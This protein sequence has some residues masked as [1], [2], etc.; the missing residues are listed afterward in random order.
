MPGPTVRVGQ[1][2]SRDLSH[3]PLNLVPSVIRFFLL[4]LSALR[5]GPAVVAIVVPRI[6]VAQ[7]RVVETTT[8]GRSVHSAAHENRRGRTCPDTDAECQSR[9]D[10][11]DADTCRDDRTGCVVVGWM[12]IGFMAVRVIAA[13]TATPLPR[14]GRVMRRGTS[15]PARIIFWRPWLVCFTRTDSPTT[16]VQ[17]M[18]VN[19][20]AVEGWS[21]SVVIR[22]ESSGRP[23]NE[24]SSVCRS[25]PARWLLRWAGIAIL[26]RYGCLGR[27]LSTNNRPAGCGQAS[28]S[29]Y[30]HDVA[31]A[32]QYKN[33]PRIWRSVG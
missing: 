7:D 15:T 20:S 31:L 6:P 18:L 24:R 1:R 5:R 32:R 27:R 14:H 19:V 17:A 26:T 30:H 33:T 10:F 12:R 8:A 9:A 3:L 28:R 29:R 2:F 16:M 21:S 13:V 23:Q 22:A 25:H 4:L 11:C